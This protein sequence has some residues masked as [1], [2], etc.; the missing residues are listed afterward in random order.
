MP[1]ILNMA[2]IDT[3]FEIFYLTNYKYIS[4]LITKVSH[5]INENN[6]FQKGQIVN[7]VA[8]DD[9]MLSIIKELPNTIKEEIEYNYNKMKAITYDLY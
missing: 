8:F 7:E 5:K 6:L 9:L 2:K 4:E 1:S 3:V